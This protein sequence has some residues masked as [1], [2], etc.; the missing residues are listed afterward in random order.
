V[1][2]S[3]TT[4]DL[5]IRAAGDSTVTRASALLSESCAQLRNS[6]GLVFPSRRGLNLP[7]A[8]ASL[9]TSDRQTGNRWQQL[10]LYPRIVVDD[11]LVSY[12]EGNPLAESVTHDEWGE[13][14]SELLDY[15][16]RAEDGLYSL[17]YLPHLMDAERSDKSISGFWALPLSR[18]T[19]ILRVAGIRD[20][21]P[22]TF[23]QVRKRACRRSLSR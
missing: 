11:R 2:A 13:A 18:V 7:S 8:A 3:W 16:F 9:G 20:G 4:H 12:S 14:S 19:A 17:H 10:A 6:T 5:T 15:L 22:C 21:I 23:V 1:P